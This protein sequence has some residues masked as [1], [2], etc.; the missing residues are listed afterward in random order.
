MN[1]EEA[2]HGSI[3]LRVTP[4]IGLT[5]DEVVASVPLI[6]TEETPCRRSNS[7]P[8]RGGLPWLG[9]A[10]QYARDPLHFLTHCARTF[11]DVVR[12]AC[13]RSDLLSAEP[14]LSLSNRSCAVA[15]RI[16]TSG[17][18]YRGTAR[19]FGNGLLTNEG[20]SWKKK[21]KLC[22]LSFQTRQVQTYAPA[23]L[24]HT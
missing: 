8:D 11:G 17:S 12:S 24:R 9:N 7:P 1:S 20:E 5:P 23:M 19:L 2:T 13:S 18:R 21:R 14:S 6:A 15:P 16:S 22:N 3:G 4:T 10:L